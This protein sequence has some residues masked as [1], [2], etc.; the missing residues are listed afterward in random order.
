MLKNYLSPKVFIFP[1]ILEMCTKLR[2]YKLHG[3]SLDFNWS[4]NRCNAH[5]CEH[6]CASKMIMW[7]GRMTSLLELFL[8]KLSMDQGKQKVI[9]HWTELRGQ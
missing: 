8:M 6:L 9:T 3:I 4:E 1:L 7:R 2:G 5:N